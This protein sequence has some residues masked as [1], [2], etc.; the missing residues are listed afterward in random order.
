MEED[1]TALGLFQRG[2]AGSA[3]DLAS[4]ESENDEVLVSEGEEQGRLMNRL[5]E[6]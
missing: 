1:V 5:L 3:S 6:R 4:E 2:G